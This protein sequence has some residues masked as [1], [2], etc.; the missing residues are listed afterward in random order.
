MNLM[1]TAAGE[2]NRGSQEQ[3]V[4]DMFFAQYDAEIDHFLPALLSIETE[5]HGIVG[6]LGINVAEHSPLFLEQYLD[7]SIEEQLSRTTETS[8]ERSSVVEVGN[9][10]ADSA[11]GARM[12]IVMLTAYL[13][14]AGF[15]WVTF[16]AL[17][18]LI[19]SF[20]RLGIPLYELANADPER[21]D[22]GGRG[23]G[24]YYQGNPRV[25]AG[26]VDEGFEVL[27]RA[28]IAERLKMAMVWAEAYTSGCRLKAA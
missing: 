14:G 8:V 5:E 7:C 1:V 3:F 25:V 11:G 16:T 19:N 2:R 9:L 27:E 15:N 4:R 26:C 22:G 23:W 13:R 12:L 17:P 28:A 10:A 24:S 6:V 18:G 20:R 21:L